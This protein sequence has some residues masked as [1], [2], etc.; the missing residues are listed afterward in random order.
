MKTLKN[1]RA[2]GADMIPKELLKYGGFALAEHIVG[3]LN[4]IFGEVTSTIGQGVL[5]PLQNP[6]KPK[7][8]LKVCVQWYC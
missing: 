3:V 5:I 8:E 2:F 7:G 1:H 4:A 6:G